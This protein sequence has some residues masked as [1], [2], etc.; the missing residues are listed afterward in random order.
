MTATGEVEVVDTRGPR[1]KMFIPCLVNSCAAGGHRMQLIN[2]DYYLGKAGKNKLN[3]GVLF[4]RPYG[5]WFDKY[6]TPYL[7]KRGVYHNWKI[8]QSI[9]LR[10]IEQLIFA[11]WNI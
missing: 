8:I 7:I 2:Y 1:M 4:S 3:K 10:S 9:K 11:H 6:P 5:R